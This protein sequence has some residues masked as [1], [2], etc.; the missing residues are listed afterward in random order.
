MG[1]HT[2][3]STIAAEL[4][5][6]RLAVIAGLDRVVRSVAAPV[7]AARDRWYADL[8]TGRRWGCSL[9]SPGL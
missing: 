7:A 9:R 6:P 4:C 8:N 1:L 2:D 3:A 5:I